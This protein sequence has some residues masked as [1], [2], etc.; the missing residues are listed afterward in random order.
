MYQRRLSALCGWGMEMG[1]TEM[2]DSQTPI[3]GQSATFSV[4]GAKRGMR[5]CCSTRTS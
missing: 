4:N 3:R 1:R 5:C 2:P